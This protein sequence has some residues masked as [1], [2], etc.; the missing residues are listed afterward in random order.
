MAA[1]LLLLSGCAAPVLAPGAAD[2][3]IVRRAT[4][5]AACTAVGNFQQPAGE[6]VDPRNVIIGLGGNTLFVTQQRI[7]IAA[8]PRTI[9]S[10]VAYRC[11]T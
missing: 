1:T 11:P 9:V 5:V 3:K 6:F 8:G 10:G 4:D 7:G 2:V